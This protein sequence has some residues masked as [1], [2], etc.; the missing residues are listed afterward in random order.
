MRASEGAAAMDSPRR[1]QYIDHIAEAS[2]LAGV[3][4]DSAPGWFDDRAWDFWRGRLS[5]SGQWGIPEQRPQRTFAR[6]RAV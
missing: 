3:M 4:R 2:V 6:A 5:R 1:L